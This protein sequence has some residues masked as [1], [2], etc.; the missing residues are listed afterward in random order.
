MGGI[1]LA[2]AAGWSS[3]SERRQKRFF[4][5]MKPKAMLAVDKS[6]RSRALI[7]IDWFSKTTGT[8]FQNGTERD[9]T[10]KRADSLD[11][12]LFRLPLMVLLLSVPNKFRTSFRYRVNIFQWQ[13]LANPYPTR[14]KS[15]RMWKKRAFC[16]TLLGNLLESL[17]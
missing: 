3:S 14:L 10:G 6:A 13:K 7:M 2:W 9:R 16:T 17:T 1:N 11:T 15:Y 12:T 5:S 4:E 8:S